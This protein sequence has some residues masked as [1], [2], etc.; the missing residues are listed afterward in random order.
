MIILASCRKRMI[1]QA[2]HDAP[3]ETCGFFSGR[4][5]WIETLHPMKNVAAEPVTRYEFDPV[6][7]F[8]ML[9]R[10][11]REGI[12]ILGVYHSHPASPAYPSMTDVGRA[13]LPDGT[14]TYLEYLYII[15]SLQ[16]PVDP[17]VRA[18][19]ILPGG[20]IQEEDLAVEEGSP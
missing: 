18:F 3:N 20:T 16:N 9:K 6:E 19:R 8:K 1:D 5:G 15:L 12:P 14:P 13:I 4:S 2:R 17:V 7:H 11:E 10:M